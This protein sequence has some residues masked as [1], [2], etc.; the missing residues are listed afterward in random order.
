MKRQYGSKYEYFGTLA[1]AKKT[2]QS[3]LLLNKQLYLSDYDL[4][5]FLRAF[6][7]DKIFTPVSVDL[8]IGKGYKVLL[9]NVS[10]LLSDIFLFP[11][12]QQTKMLVTCQRFGYL[13]FGLVWQYSTN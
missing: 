1:T 13:F 10:F 11:K 7:F 8:H 9:H 5:Q 2:Y 6:F 4:F 3:A 12:I